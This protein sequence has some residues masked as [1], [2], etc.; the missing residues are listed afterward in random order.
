VQPAAVAT[1]ASQQA[2]RARIVAAATELLADREY[3]RIQMRDVA[4]AAD[5]A[6]GTLYRYFRSKDQLFAAVLLEWSRSFE[7]RVQ[8]WDAAGS[9]R[10]R[11]R[12]ALRRAARAFE[13]QPHF[14]QLLSVLEPA[15]DPDVTGPFREYAEGFTSVLAGALAGTDPEDAAVIAATSGVIL[16]NLLRRWSR[17]ELPMRSVYDQVDRLVDLLFDG[18]RPTPS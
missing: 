6:L 4:A 11:L 1:T 16:D 8:R 9:D 10:D 13:R 7:A 3:E 12:L 18:A 5:V 2:R 15:R 14:F 17:G